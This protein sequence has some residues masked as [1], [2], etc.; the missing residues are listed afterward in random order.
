MLF[1]LT[2]I[3]TGGDG[4]LADELAEALA[5]IHD[6]HLPYQLTPSATCI[7]GSWDEVMPVIRQCHERLRTT[8]PHVFTSIRI[9]EHE[10]VEEYL[11]RNLSSVSD[12]ADRPI[13]TMPQ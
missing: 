9:E 3:T 10:G 12:R 2:L 7:E 1:E 5:I 8:S 13:A 11:R 6:S 4:H